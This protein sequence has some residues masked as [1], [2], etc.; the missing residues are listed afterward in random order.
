MKTRITLLLALALSACGG[1]GQSPASNTQICFAGICAPTI[2][3]LAPAV[4]ARDAF[5]AEHEFSVAD[6]VVY[7]PTGQID[8]VAAVQYPPD[9]SAQLASGQWVQESDLIQNGP[10]YSCDGQ[11]RPA[12]P[13]PVEDL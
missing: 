4:A 7:C 11:R 8:V 3:S 12:A 10:P 1:A 13:T 5:Y 2:E 6:S 9:G